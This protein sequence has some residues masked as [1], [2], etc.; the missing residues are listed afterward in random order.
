MN[1]MATLGM[2]THAMWHQTSGHLAHGR[3]SA[4]FLSCM[5]IVVGDLA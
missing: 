3:L 1:D 5:I 4:M 2:K